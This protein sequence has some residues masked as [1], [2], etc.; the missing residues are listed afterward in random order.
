MV[1]VRRRWHNPAKH[2]D[3]TTEGKCPYCKK[4][5]QALEDHIHDK[6]KGEKL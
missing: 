5:V 4:H 6:H 1:K 3:P 2:I